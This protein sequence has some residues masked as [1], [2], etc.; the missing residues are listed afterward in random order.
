MILI[1][2]VTQP[3]VQANETIEHA[4]RCTVHFASLKVLSV[5]IGAKGKK[6]CHCLPKKKNSEVITE[7]ETQRGKQGSRVD[8]FVITGRA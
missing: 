7:T 3:Y 1:L 2:H 8:S 6:E 5:K 4:A